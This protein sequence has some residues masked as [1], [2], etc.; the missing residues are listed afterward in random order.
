MKRKFRG[1][2]YT[3]TAEFGNNVVSGLNGENVTPATSSN[4]AGT[5]DSA[6][7]TKLSN[8]DDVY[9]SAEHENEP[10]TLK[11]ELSTRN[12]IATKLIVLGVNC[13]CSNP[14]YKSKKCKGDLFESNVRFVYGMRAIGKGP[15]AAK[16]LCG[17]LDLPQ[18]LSGM[19]KYTE[20]IGIAVG[21][22]AEASMKTAAEE[23][24]QLNDGDK[25]IPVA[26]YGTW[27]KRGHTSKNSVTAATSVDS[28]K[29]LDFEVLTKHCFKCNFPTE[30]HNYDKKNYE[31]TSGRMEAAAAVKIWNRSE[32]DRNVC[33]TELLGDGDSVALKR[34]VEENPYKKK[35]I[36]QIEFVGHVQKIMGTRL[37]KLK[38][39]EHSTPEAVMEVVK[40]IYRDLDH[41]DLLRKCLH[42]K[43]QNPNESFNNLTFTRLPKNV[44]VVLK[45]LQWNVNYAVISFNEGNFGRFKV[46]QELY[47]SPGPNAVKTSKFLDKVRIKKS[48]HAAELSTKEVRVHKRKRLLKENEEMELVPAYG[49]R[50]H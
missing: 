21:T 17:I 4:N 31:D 2:R 47:I 14:F 9:S 41:P 13:N 29:V 10:V 7:K 27:Q 36:R 38:H 3:K 33:Y 49:A 16:L 30:E 15:T 44:F 50:C 32:K 40:P 25:N 24:I 19:N 46:L 23:A 20:V 28:G 45:I 37:R 18:P 35:E 22:V 43:T 39:H 42:G 5:P 34:V 12:G 6:S 8:S 26:F 11:E 48:H 1:N